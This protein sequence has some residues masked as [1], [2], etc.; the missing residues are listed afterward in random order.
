MFSLSAGNLEPSEL[1][2]LR[3]VLDEICT[4]RG[5]QVTNPGAQNIANDLLYWWQFGVRHPEQLKEMMR[6][7]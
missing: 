1:S 6:A 3:Q 4:E 7:L 2:L 5:I